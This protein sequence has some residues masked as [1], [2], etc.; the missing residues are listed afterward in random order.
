MKKIFILFILVAL[1]IH[2]SQG[3][4]VRVTGKVTGKDDGSVLPGVTISIKGTTM[5]TMSESDGSYAL[6]VPPGSSVLVFSFVGFKTQ[7]VPVG[8]RSVIDVVLETDVLMIDEV[9]VVA[10]GTTKKDAFTGSASSV[11]VD[12][13]AEIQ[14]S[15]V[16]KALD[17]LSSGIQVTSG[18]GQPGT[19]TAVRIRGIG[20]IYASTSP[21]YV[22]D[23]FPFDGDLNSIPQN[24]I[25]TLTVLKDASATALYGS[26]AAN[27]VIVIT[28]KK[29]RQNENR[30]SF[31]ANVGFNVRGIPEYE[32][33]NVPQYYELQWEN[34]QNLFITYY[35]MGREEAADYSSYYL[36]SQLGNYNAYNVPDG[37]VVGTDGKINP[38]AK[39]LWTDN[40]FNA[41]HRTG[42]R[43]D[44]TLSASGGKEKST[45]F[46]SG[47]YLKDEG[48][49][50]SSDYTR[51]TLRV[52]ADTQ[53]KDWLRLGINS[54]VSTSDQNYPVSAGTAFVNSFMWSRIIAPI[55][56]VYLYDLNGVLQRDEEGHKMYDYGNEFG[57]SRSFGALEN[58][59]GTIM[60]D[61]NLF[62]KDNV[63]SKGF[64]EVSFLRDFRF[65]VNLNADYEGH[66]NLEY[67]NPEFGD[68]EAYKGFCKR[69]SSRRITVSANELLNWNKTVKSH[70]FDFLA[71]H[72]SYDFK[73]N[74]LSASRSGFPF[75][76]QYELD[77]AAV[78]E[79]AGSYEDTFTMESYFS[80]LN[81]NYNDRYYLSLSARTDGSS[82]FARDSRWGKF[83]SAGAS[84]R[85]SQESFMSGLTW[86][87]DLKLKASYGSQGND[88]LGTFY[89]Y[90]GLYDFGY[91]N[92]NY[93]GIFASRLPTPDLLWEKNITMNAGVEFTILDRL[94]VNFELYNRRS[95]DL[96]FPV[97]L[98]SSTGYGS[99]D[100]NVGAMKN[101]GFD[102]DAS[103]VIFNKARFKWTTDLNLSHYKN[104][105]TKMP[106]DQEQIINGSKKWMVG[107]SIYDYYIQKYVGVDPENGKAIWNT[108]DADG[109]IITTENY[110]YADKFYT[111]SSSIPDLQG[112][113]TNTFR[114]GNIDLS[115]LVTFGLGGKILD[116]SYQELM[117]NSPGYAMHKD[118]LKRWTP[119]NT[120]TDVPILDYDI[121]SNETSDRWL[122]SMSFLNIRSLTVGYNLPEKWVSALHIS[123]ARLSMMVTNLHLF[124]ARKGL[125]PQQ[126]FSGTT[127]DSY[128]P[129]RTT[130]VNFSM[131]F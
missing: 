101:T 100:A 50:K 13:L 14:T 47:N 16:T 80:R 40:W 114:Y 17:G 112:G 108:T 21:L 95:V 85:I 36:V 118:M 66:S 42:I 54:S 121:N 86:L 33:V 77:A 55:Y 10:Y 59:L 26:R 73:Y 106:K 30:L 131:N 31:I 45:Y 104:E 72:E 28:T 76:G 27:G 88:N 67:L 43:R 91:N 130:S 52:N 123:D 51:F 35:G 122:T 15:N 124:S 107:H 116:G 49:V 19:T 62:K 8:G 81:Y 110:S 128:T 69:T 68:G 61:K 97:P 53:A 82:R 37:E 90:I 7:E 56:P 63:Q 39:L 12:K 87:N 99:Y 65:T 89:A 38:D 125:D 46:I 119:T 18:S 48:I 70:S 129:L 115:F 111:G 75:P 92:V 74:Y 34:L 64:V 78:L 84:W 83:W 4:S 1:S 79:G 9:M 109:S 44:Y 105:I 11:K 94:T 20:S 57:R 102:L 98:P 127:D 113:L 29:G 32:R 58:P 24:D 103:F 93:P 3:Q 25:A 5:G 117:G 41:M 96:L 22:V 60:L 23:G 2:L 126:S 71:G 120:D 6:D